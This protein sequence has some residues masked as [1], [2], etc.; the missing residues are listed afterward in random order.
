M[1]YRR[2]EKRI[3]NLRRRP[4]EWIKTKEQGYH[5]AYGAQYYVDAFNRLVQRGW[6]KCL[7]NELRG[8]KTL[9]S[10]EVQACGCDS[11]PSAKVSI[12]ARSVR[13][14]NEA[15][16]KVGHDIH[17]SCHLSFW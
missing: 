16:D 9:D 15:I 13:I 3:D 14:M 8:V 7:Y 17:R 5:Q 11:E 6:S 4:L 12:T 1:T 10:E 2:G